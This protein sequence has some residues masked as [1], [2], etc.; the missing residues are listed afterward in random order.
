V[1]IDQS[2]PSPQEKIAAR[3]EDFVTMAFHTSSNLIPATTLFVSI[4]Q[5]G[6]IF[7]ISMS[8]QLDTIGEFSASFRLVVLTCYCS[9]ANLEARDSHKGGM[10]GENM[11][12][13]TI[14][15]LGTGNLMPAVFINDP[16]FLGSNF[17]LE[18]FGWEKD[19]R[20]C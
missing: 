19:K 8:G 13:V 1:T 16:S 11:G 7:I 15:P 5:A 9:W 18:N 6:W 20:S 4:R 12:P 3:L 17:D 14:E 2:I 10:E